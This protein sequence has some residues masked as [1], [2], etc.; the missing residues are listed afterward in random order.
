M[1][2]TTKDF[3]R[4]PAGACVLSVGEFELGEFGVEGVFFGLAELDGMEGGGVD[5]VLDPPDGSD[6]G[7]E[8][9]GQRME[10]S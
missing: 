4:I 10:S 1:N 9:A 5:V 6:G 8:A 7:K 2:E 3:S